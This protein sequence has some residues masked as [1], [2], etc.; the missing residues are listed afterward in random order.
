M[1]IVNLGKLSGLLDELNTF[2]E[3]SCPESSTT[4]LSA[5]SPPP[6]LQIFLILA[7]ISGNLDK[8]SGLS[9]S[10]IMF[11]HQFHKVVAITEDRHIKTV[12]YT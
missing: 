1:T 9:D 4:D 12:C 11:K 5:A 8:M 10:S 2:I 3:R 7:C 6:T